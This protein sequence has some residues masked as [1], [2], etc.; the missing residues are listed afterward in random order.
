VTKD[1][2][3]GQALLVAPAQELGAPTAEAPLT[4]QKLFTMHAAYVWNTLRRFGIASSDLE[5]VTHDVF[6]QVHRHFADYETGRPIRPWLFAFAYRAAS[7]YRRTARRR[8][9]T[10]GE[11]DSVAHPGAAADEQLI[12]DDNRRLVAAAL[13]RIPLE[14]RAVF[15]LYEI[16]GVAT[17]EIAATLGIP[18]NTAYSRLRLA[19]SEFASAVKHLRRQ[20]GEP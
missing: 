6:L 11:P 14:R 20:R 9:E 12:A 16:D 3:G 10:P 13:A 7:Q 1:P 17:S 15:I 4:L 18:L 5:D 8:R 19:R 2:P